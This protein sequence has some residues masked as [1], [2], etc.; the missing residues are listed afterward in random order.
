MKFN[1]GRFSAAADRL[2]RVYLAALRFAVLLVATVA[3]L[4]A[5][6][7]A[8][9]GVRRLL[10]STEVEQQP[11]SVGGAEVVQRMQASIA[12]RS[13]EAASETP[14]IP[15]PVRRAHAAFLAGP[16]DPLYQ[17]YRTLATRYNKPEDR[18]LTKPALAAELGY[19]ADAVAAREDGRVVAF[20]E[21]PR[22]ASQM[23]AASA[24]LATERGVTSQ[25]AKYKA[26]QKTAQQC[27]TRER[28]VRGWDSTSIECPEWYMAPV[29]CPVTRQ[30]PYQACV[31]V[32]PDN[33]VSPL[34]T[35]ASFDAHFAEVW[36]ERD[37]ESASEAQNERERLA[38]IKAQGQPRLSQAVVILA[39]FLAIMFLFL[40]IA[41][42]RHLR[43]LSRA[44]EASTG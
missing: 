19:T 11:V 9:D 16:F 7:F 10:T 15:A 36:S 38:L 27:T 24:S 2:E 18:L 39:A 14:A 4:L 40:V 12:E 5:V 32:Y 30:E 23:G 8:G 41:V 37:S 33:I 22:Y 25:L 31:A 3:L 42:E 17:S 26:A 21:N 43:R 1:T 35:V 6:G 20:A 34:Q 13:A 29:G 28:S 44:A